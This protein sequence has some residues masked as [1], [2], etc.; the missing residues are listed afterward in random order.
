[1][2][3]CEAHWESRYDQR[4]AS[5]EEYVEAMAKIKQIMGSGE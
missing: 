1:M 4:P 3:F 2:G 5:R